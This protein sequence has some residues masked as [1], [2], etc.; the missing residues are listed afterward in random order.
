MVEQQISAAMRQTFNE[1]LELG[2][3]QGFEAGHNVALGYR[4]P[5]HEEARWLRGLHARSSFRPAR[6][7]RWA[8]WLG[9][10]SVLSVAIGAMAGVGW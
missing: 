4:D 8:L 3:K 1:G 5:N 9:A 7:H 6:G 2:R 10:A